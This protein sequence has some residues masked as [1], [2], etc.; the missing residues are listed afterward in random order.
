[1][2][3]SKIICHIAGLTDHYKD[4]I[5]IFIDK[6]SNIITIIDLDILTNEIIE[7]E[8]M[9]CLEEKYNELKKN[10]NPKS[11]DLEQEMKDYWLEEFKKLLNDQINNIENKIILIGSSVHY[12]FLNKKLDLE[13]ENKI[14]I[15]LD[16]EKYSR[17]MIKENIE[18]YKEE[19]INGNFP[20][21]YL[22]SN[23]LM[24]KRLAVQK[25]YQKLEYKIMSW[26]KIIEFLNPCNKEKEFWYASFDKNI[27]N[28]I[29][30]F[31]YPWLAIAN[32]IN[33]DVDISIVNGQP[34]INEK[35]ELILQS[36]KTKGYLFQ[37]SPNN[38]FINKSNHYQFKIKRPFEIVKE[39]SLDN[40][41]KKLS[42]YNVKFTYY[43]ITNNDN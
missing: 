15:D 32:L 37:V 41:F 28:K 12:K 11:K 5:K 31:H 19:I 16:L 2:N 18:K 1:M 8:E 33:K 39:I 4:K 24:K 22:S 3:T 34:L 35:K 36:L 6:I 43:G 21:D 13:I 42:S 26:N 23:Y 7:R 40:I 30:V 14:F 20:L 38:I 17:L 10:S 29:K 27:P 9:I 25:I